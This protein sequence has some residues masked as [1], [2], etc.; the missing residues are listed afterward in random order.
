MATLNWFNSSNMVFSL[1]FDESQ[2]ESEFNELVYGLIE[3][4]NHIPKDNSLVD[5]L[6]DERDAYLNAI[7]DF[8][9]DELATRKRIDRLKHTISQFAKWGID[10]TPM[11]LARKLI[12]VIDG[13]DFD[14]T[15]IMEPIEY[16]DDLKDV[17]TFPD[18]WEE[19]KNLRK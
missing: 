3:N 19:S 2:A 12:S 16:S 5:R 18:K 10:C 7:N 14:D 15:E 6:I 4:S 11:A 1:E 9:E 8:R 17:E 13:T